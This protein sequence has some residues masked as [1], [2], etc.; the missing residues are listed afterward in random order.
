MHLIQV[1]RERTDS[2]KASS[3]GWKSDYCQDIDFPNVSIWEPNTD[4]IEDDD[5]VVITF[6]VAGVNKEDL[7][8][9][10]KSSDL[11][12][13]GVRRENRPDKKIYFHRLEINY[14]F[15][16]KVVSLPEALV[17]NDIT[18]HL[19]DGLLQVHIS[20]KSQV[21]E[22]PIAVKSNRKKSS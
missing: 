6:E 21:I 20:K 2:G 4:I 5:E 11:Y 9:K 19:K 1:I 12:V 3:K 13:T 7:C 15:L 8:V 22:I 10:L 16:G 18:A 17:H 14:G